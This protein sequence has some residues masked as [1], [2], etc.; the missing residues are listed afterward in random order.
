MRGSLRG[1]LSRVDRLEERV[2]PAPDDWLARLSTMS[3]AE[4]NER[5]ADSVEAQGGAESCFAQTG[6]DV[7]EHPEVQRILRERRL[8]QAAGLV[9]QARVP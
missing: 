3:D 4:L 9:K 6:F 5:L 1:V 2:R 8:G 7:G